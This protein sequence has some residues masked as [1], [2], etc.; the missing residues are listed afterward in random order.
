[1]REKTKIEQTTMRISQQL[2]ALSKVYGLK[3][4]Y[5]VQIPTKTEYSFK[6]L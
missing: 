3:E 2:M 6:S 4:V 1:M 5:A